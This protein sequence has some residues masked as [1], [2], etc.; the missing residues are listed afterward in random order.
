MTQKTPLRKDPLTEMNV[1]KKM[2]PAIA[3]ELTDSIAICNLIDLDKQLTFHLEIF[4][5]SL[6][7]KN[8]DQV[9]ENVIIGHVQVIKHGKY[10]VS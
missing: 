1:L 9:K 8:N 10:I 4:H 7:H 2:A 6:L 3:F 5:V